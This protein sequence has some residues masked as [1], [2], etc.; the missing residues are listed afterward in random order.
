M[1]RRTFLS[2]V[3]GVVALSAI[4]LILL[5]AAPNQ[6][7][8]VALDDWSESL[9]PFLA[10]IACLHTAARG[11]G[12]TRQ[13]WGL[14]GISA[15]CW[16]FG[17]VA[18]S[19]QEVVLNLVP[20]DL[21]PSYPDVGYLSAVPF[22][23]AGLLRLPGSEETG[24]ARL[25][26]LLDG[27]VIAG[28]F[29]FI[30]WDLVLGPIYSVSAT[31]LF[32]QAVGLA[33]PIS[34]IA[35]VSIV[36]LMLSRLRVGQRLPLGL[37]ACGVLLNAVADSSF[38]YLTT[39][40]NYGSAN[41]L[42]VGWTMGYALIGLAAFS[43]GGATGHDGT[44]ETRLPRWNLLLPYW[45]LAVAGVLAIITEVVAGS[46]SRVL[47]WDLLFTTCVVLIRQFLFVQQTQSL[48]SEV[49]NKNV[50]LDRQVH[51]RTGELIDSLEALHSTNDE[52]TRLLLRL[53]TLQEDERQH[54]AGVI[55]DDMLQS[56]IAAKMRMFLLHGG[57]GPDDGTIASVEAAVDR[58]IL[59][60]RSLMSDLRPQILDLGL[61][62]AVEQ[63][64]AEFNEDGSLVVSLRNQ[65]H[66]DPP[67]IVGTTLYRIVREAL[68]N[69]SKHAPG[70]A[71]AVIL[72]GD[73]EMGFGARV[74]D[75]G[76]GFTPQHDGRSPK[77]HLGLSSMRESAEALGGWVRIG[78]GAGPGA[79]IEV[80]LPQRPLLL[81]EM[82][83]A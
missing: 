21:F 59:R 66:G 80:W 29:L 47:E 70:A 83:A 34:D 55:H 71:V 15:A 50:D 35:M 28:G 18:W 43:V 57:T 2:L 79:V 54:I 63:A 26:S 8:T 6:R 51:L 14:I 42:D 38:A 27:M 19:V 60:M 72:Q 36:V 67:P 4:N 1:G 33:Y 68:V 7:A 65:L 52:R 73:P 17:Q 12:R 11:S 76:P 32:S 3:A 45:T 46:L 48:N 24:P 16:C 23:L 69:A 44:E 31:D 10:A 64:I 78:S 20:A 39:V 49:A 62:P 81:P 56:M 13:A 40:Q 61:L 37:L 82:P 53:V 74:S 30:S 22:A 77:G 75:D 41:F 9:T 25:R 5:I 58:A